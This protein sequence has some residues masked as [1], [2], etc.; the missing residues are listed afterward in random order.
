MKNISIG[1]YGPRE[2]ID[3]G[4]TGYIEGARNDGS[5]WILFLDADGSPA[6]YWADRD[7]G[8]GVIGDPVILTDVPGYSR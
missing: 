2:T 4:Y 3:D 6:L 5:T 7:S 8:G 1:R